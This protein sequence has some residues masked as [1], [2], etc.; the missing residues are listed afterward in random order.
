MKK[1]I[2]G[3]VF[4][5]LLL[6]FSLSFVIA[7]NNI[8]CSSNSDCGVE[9][10]SYPFCKNETHICTTTTTPTCKNAT[11]NISSC[12]DI[13]K[14]TCWV[15]ENGCEDRACVTAEECDSDN[16]NLCLNENDCISANGSWNNSTCNEKEDEENKENEETETEG[17]DGLGQI[18]RNRVKAGVYT[19]PTGEQIRVSELAKNRFLLQ[20]D[21]ED[22]NAETELEIEQET[23][24][25]KTKLKTK[26][27]NG[28]EAEIKI[29]PGVAS[30]KALERL[31]LKVCNSDNNCII[32]LKE[33]GSAKDSQLAYELQAERHARILAMFKVKMQVKAQV[34]AETGELIRVKKPWWAFLATEPEE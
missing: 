18:I 16:L 7:D 8:T 1:I 6:S 2:L 10:T 14:D 21:D 22:A 4:G 11:T 32:E 34:D 15:C 12:N 5:I 29:M 9:S 19:S 31:R 23:E 13:K 24:N 3:L 20:F 27:S 33:V 30:E 25:N 26:L 28:K 17:K